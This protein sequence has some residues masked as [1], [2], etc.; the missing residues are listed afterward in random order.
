V[1]YKLKV[2]MGKQGDVLDL[3]AGSEVIDCR[4]FADKY[5]VTYLVPAAADSEE[6]PAI[7]AP[8]FA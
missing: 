8:I 2:W 1:K 4:P 3:P 5:T 7:P 6:K